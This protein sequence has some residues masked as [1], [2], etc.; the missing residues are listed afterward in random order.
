MRKTVLF[1]MLLVILASFCGLS[2]LFGRAVIETEP[3]LV[4]QLISLDNSP[5]GLKWKETFGDNIETRQSF[6]L[7]LL[8]DAY[9]K[10]GKRIEI[11]EANDPN[12]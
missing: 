6:N 1:T 5:A 4:D 12:K 9:I 11:L 3:K 2:Y 8:N 10:F 7:S